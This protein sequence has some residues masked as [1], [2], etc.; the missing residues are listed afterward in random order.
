MPTVSPTDR[1]RKVT[2]PTADR[3]RPF[4]LLLL[5]LAGLLGASVVIAV[6][7]GG[8]AIAPGTVWAVI[9]SEL[10]GPVAAEV[11]VSDRQIVWELRLPR[12]LLAAIVGA[13]LSVAG[14]AIQALVR[15]ALADPY[16]L[17]VSSGASVGATLVILFGFLTGLGSYAISAAAFAGA[18]AAMV[19]VYVVA[20]QGGRVAPLR[21]VLAGVAIGY[22][23]SALTSFLVFQTDA[24]ASQSV[25]F[26]LLGSFGRAQ[27]AFVPLPAVLVAAGCAYLMLRARALNALLAGAETAV[28]LGVAVPRFRAALFIV[29]AAMTGVMVAV[30]GAIGFVGLIMPHVV[31]LLVGA[32]HRRVL[33]VAALAGAVFMVWVDVAARAVVAPQELPVG[34]ITAL[35]GGPAFVWLMRRRPEALAPS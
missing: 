25:L 15:N 3:R 26:W 10:G 30:S 4:G 16:I 11:V 20:Q 5:T 8:A 14:V 27:W 23:L 17:G 22:V 2:A 9:V 35:V 21:L 24:Q 31:R 33:P 12:T 7:I 1:V 28:T 34:I 29:T 6:G 13:G 32:D 18:L 19:V